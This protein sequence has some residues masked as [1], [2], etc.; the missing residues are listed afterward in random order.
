MSYD[1]FKH[2]CTSMFTADEII[3]I[4]FVLNDENIGVLINSMSMTDD[5]RKPL[6]VVGIVLAVKSSFTENS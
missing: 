4:C 5:K 6:S 3:K 2:L 1:N